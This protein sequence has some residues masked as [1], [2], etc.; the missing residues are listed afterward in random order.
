MA[1]RIK[2]TLELLKKLRD[3]KA[4][5]TVFTSRFEYDSMVLNRIET[6]TEKV[7]FG[8]FKLNFRHIT[9][10]TNQ[11][12]TAPKPRE[13]RALPQVDS[14]SQSLIDQLKNQLPKFPPGESIAHYL[15][16]PP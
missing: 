8:E 15:L 13:P 10:V 5:C 7:G 6:N 16:F 12:T 3:T 11:T 2:R 9:I 1:D 4:L 14:G